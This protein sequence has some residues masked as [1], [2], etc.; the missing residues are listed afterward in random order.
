MLKSALKRVMGPGHLD[1]AR[2][3][4]ARISNFG[5]A[6]YCPCCKSYLRH[7]Y[8]FGVQ[9]RGGCDVPSLRVIRKASLDLALLH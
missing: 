7:F 6:R 2:K 3:G 1:F 9:P 5:F 4:I 8:P